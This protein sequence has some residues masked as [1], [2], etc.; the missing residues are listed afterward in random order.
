MQCTTYDEYI[1]DAK[2]EG[3]FHGLYWFR[4]PHCNESFEYDDGPFELNGFKMI[5]K[6]TFICGKC[7]KKYRIK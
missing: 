5:D 1:P 4:C 3:L 6:H 2:Y 7:G